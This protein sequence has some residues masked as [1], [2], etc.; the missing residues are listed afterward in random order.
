MRRLNATTCKQCFRNVTSLE[1]REALG[2]CGPS[3]EES[4]TCRF[5]DEEEFEEDEEWSEDTSEDEAKEATPQQVE[6]GEEASNRANE[7][8]EVNIT[9]GE[10]LGDYETDEEQEDGD[11]DWEEAPQGRY[12]TNDDR[13]DLS[14]TDEPPSPV[15][16]SRSISPSPSTTLLDRLDLNN[17]PMTEANQ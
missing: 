3:L 17:C 15:A 12:V 16:G 2:L 7:E 6:K 13:Y 5:L 1:I 10:D 4:D 8:E 14:V 11:E 9:D